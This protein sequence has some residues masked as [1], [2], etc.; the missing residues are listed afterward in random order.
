MILCPKRYVGIVKKEMQKKGA[1]GF[2]NSVY[3]PIDLKI[4]DSD[5][6]TIKQWKNYVSKSLICWLV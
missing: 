4:K 1:I 6:V 3:N 5:S 2:K